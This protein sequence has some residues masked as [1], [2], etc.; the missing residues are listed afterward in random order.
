[1]GFNQFLS[2]SD[3]SKYSNFTVC[4]HQGTRWQMLID[5]NTF[6]G[7]LCF[8]TLPFIMVCSPAPNITISQGKLK[9]RHQVVLYKYRLGSKGVCV[10]SLCFRLNMKYWGTSV[11]TPL[12]PCVSIL[13]IMLIIICNN[14]PEW[15]SER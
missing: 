2:K 4:N 8:L 10:I 13:Q 3:S 7:S 1:M 11:V 5:T 9:F 14:F 6:T 12:T 15:K